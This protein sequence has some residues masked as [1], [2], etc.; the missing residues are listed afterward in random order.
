[1][2]EEKCCCC[3]P[4]DCGVKTIAVLTMISTVFNTFF[5]IAQPELRA[6][7]VPAAVALVV[8]SYFWLAAWCS[9]SEG[10]K[11]A[12]SL[13]WLVLAVVFGSI[14]KLYNIFSGKYG[15]YACSEATLAEHNEFADA[16]G[17]PPLT[18]EECRAQ[19]SGWLWGDFALALLVNLYFLS[20]IIRWSKQSDGY[21]AI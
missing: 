2:G 3:L 13:A 8:L 12:V 21:E 9:P 17:F 20:V 11:K 4:L 14:L 7:Y 5:A 1:M 16:V 18:E 6:L 10:S 15:D 19:Q